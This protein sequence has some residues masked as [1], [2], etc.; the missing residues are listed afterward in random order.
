[1]PSIPYHDHTSSES[2]YLLDQESQQNEKPSQKIKNV[3]YFNWQWLVHAIFFT[4]SLTV[5]FAAL[6]ISQ[7][8][9][10]HCAYQEVPACKEVPTCERFPATS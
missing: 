8:A 2:V 1:M 4:I 7:T 5:L 6:A 9:H 3:L 10:E